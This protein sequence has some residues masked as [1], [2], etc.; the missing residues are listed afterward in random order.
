MAPYA[1]R[2]LDTSPGL[3]INEANPRLARASAFEKRGSYQTAYQIR[4]TEHNGSTVWNTNKVT[5]WQQNG[6]EYAGLPL[7][8]CGE[9]E[10]KVRV[11]NQE[12]EMTDWTRQIILHSISLPISVQ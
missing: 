5:S 12:N 6:V 1:L 8:S 3:A 2:V 9:Y 7:R 10:W 4:V 11:W